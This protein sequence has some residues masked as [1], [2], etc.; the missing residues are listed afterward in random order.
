MTLSRGQ[1][2]KIDRFIVLSQFMK[3]THNK[4]L[5]DRISLLPPFIPQETLSGKVVDLPDDFI[6]FVGA[7]TPNKGVDVLIEAYRK[8]NPKTKL[9]LIGG[10]HPDYQYASDANIIVMPNVS[11][12]VVLQAYEKCRFAVFPSIWPEPLGIVTLEA[13]SHK[14]AVIATNIGGFK[15]TVIN[16]ET[17]LLVSTPNLVDAMSELLDNPIKAT[18]MGEKGYER[19]INNFTPEVVIPKYVELYKVV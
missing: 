9:V 14:K 6:L 8:L 5:S 4:Y 16:G 15:D 1:L 11:R 10:K 19:Y 2:K 13:M 3:E 7:L 12:D 17:G 18:H